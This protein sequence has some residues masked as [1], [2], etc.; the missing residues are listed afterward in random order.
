MVRKFQLSKTQNYGFFNKPRGLI[1]T[2]N[3]PN[4]RPTVFNHLKAVGFPSEHIISIGR[5]D[6]NS[7]GL[8]LLTNDGELSRSI[9]LPE[10]R[11]ERTYRVRVYGGLDE[12]KLRK[13]QNG[14]TISG[15]TYGPYFAEIENKQT[16]NTWLKMRLTTGKYREIRKIMQK[17]SLRVNRLQR[18]RY[19][20]YT[21][22]NLSTGEYAEVSIA[23]QL[24]KLLYKQLEK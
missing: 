23:P 15:V 14:A 8:L 11:L 13:I 19:G 2:H 4:N 5:L 21:L 17:F 16:S 18:I 3:D 7:E 9:E 20:P 22:G 6:Y 10:S 12:E 24:K 1:C